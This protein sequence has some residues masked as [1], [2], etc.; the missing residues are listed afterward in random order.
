[1]IKKI[2]STADDRAIKKR[3]VTTSTRTTPGDTQHTLTIHKKSYESSVQIVC[4]LGFP[5]T[6]VIYFI[7]TTKMFK[8]ALQVETDNPVFRIFFLF[9][10]QQ[11][12]F[13]S[14]NYVKSVRIR[15]FPV[16]YFPVFGRNAGKYDQ[17]NSE[18]GQFFR[19]VNLKSQ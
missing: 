9:L 7:M 14:I 19:S 6:C 5:E 13:F 18:Y 15:I 8:M 3:R 12:F 1:M 16:P 4:P 10:F 17:R 2:I 11:I